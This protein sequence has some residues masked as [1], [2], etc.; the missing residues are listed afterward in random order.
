MEKSIPRTIAEGTFWISSSTLWIKVI[1]LVSVLLMLRSLG[2]AE[3]GSLELTLSM[4]ALFSIFM[5]PGLDMLITADMSI[6]KGVGAFGKALGILRMFFLLQVALAFTAFAVAF[7]T[8]EWWGHLYDIS[9]THV[10]LVALL[11]L[12]GPVRTAYSVLFRVQLRFF[13]QSLITFL[14]EAAKMVILASLFFLSEITIAGVILAMVAAQAVA[15]VLLAV[16]FARTWAS[17]GAGNRAERISRGDSFLGR[18]VWTVLTT[19]VGNL[20]KTA[21]LWIIQR[22]LGAEAVGLYAVALGLIGHTLA[23]VPLYSVLSP[24]LSQYAHERERFV[25]ILNKGMK[26]QF[27]AYLLVGVAAFF[28]FPPVI[29]WLFPTYAAA[30]P[31]FKVML[32]GL[33]PVA[34][35]SVLTPAFFALKLQKNF[36]ASMVFKTVVS[37]VCTFGLVMLF[38]LWGLAYEY[39]LTSVLYGLERLRSLRKHVSG[40]SVSWRYL[41]SFDDEDRLLLSKSLGFLYA[42]A[43]FLRRQESNSALD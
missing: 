29:S 31:L 36:F 19:Y 3:Y 12:M 21:R 26:Y 13:L 28:A 38:G 2:V 39:T 8:A 16:P 14:E 40:V 1:S 9:P 37:L 24:L 18:G 35:I 17:L 42:Q 30:M 4:V 6:A 5:L 34:F 20:G 22:L 15:L 33:V 32:L 23:L 43:P 11:F 25:K 7:L 10:R 27:I 41:S